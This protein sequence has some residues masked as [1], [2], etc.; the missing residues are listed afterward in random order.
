[1]IAAMGNT[2][3]VYGRTGVHLHF[4][5]QQNGVYHDLSYYFSGLKYNPN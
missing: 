1:M 5:V 4:E 3:R 2:G